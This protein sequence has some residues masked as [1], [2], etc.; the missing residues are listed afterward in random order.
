MIG[1][2][3]WKSVVLIASVSVAAW[4]GMQQVHELGHVLGA[5]ATGGEVE[6]VVLHPLTISRTDLADNPQP[7]LVVWAG[8]LIGILLPLVAWSAALAARLRI[9]FLLR[10][11]AGFCLI[12]NGAYIG[13]GSFGGIGDCGEMLRHGS[14][15]WLL[16]LFGLVTVPAGL[17]LW[18]GQGKH[19][20]IGAPDLRIDSVALY[21]SI[22]ALAVLLAIS[23]CAG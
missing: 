15:I 18:N 4:L 8:P 6:R 1:K 14:P 20:G 3:G 23:L 22:T 7:L 2:P 12:A 13:A 10:F 5:V 11:F 19:F 16:W 21:T 9:A 17:A